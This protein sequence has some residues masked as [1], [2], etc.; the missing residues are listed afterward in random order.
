MPL[1][2]PRNLPPVIVY[3][4]RSMPAPNPLCVSHTVSIHLN[5][6]LLRTW[7]VKCLCHKLVNKYVHMYMVV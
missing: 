3:Y 1:D 2:P 7:S 4:P 5:L 6:Y